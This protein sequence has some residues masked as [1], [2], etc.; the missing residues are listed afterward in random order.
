MKSIA[1]PLALTAFAALSTL[2]FSKPALAGDCTSFL[3]KLESRSFS[4]CTVTLDGR[5]EPELTQFAIVASSGMT[6]SD[7]KVTEHAR[8]YHFVIA[9][10]DGA[11]RGMSGFTSGFDERAQGMLGTP[12]RNSCDESSLSFAVTRDGH[13]ATT[14]RVALGVSGH[15]VEANVI[16][17]GKPELAVTCASSEI[18]R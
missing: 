16:R 10:K 2:T 5:P 15:A 14:G 1:R 4:D 9:A 12:S 6:F 13:V 17:S 3:Q 8:Y 18:K 11:A 7:G